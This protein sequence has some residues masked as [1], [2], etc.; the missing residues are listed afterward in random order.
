MLIAT[1]KEIWYMYRNT[2]CHLGNHSLSI[3]KGE[4]REGVAHIALNDL[5]MLGGHLVV[6]D[7]R[8]CNIITI[9]II[10]ILRL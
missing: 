8:A 10:P 7:E 3:K 9:I 4:S 6:S 5:C 2:R 1:V